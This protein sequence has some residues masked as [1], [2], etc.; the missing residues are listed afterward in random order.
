[1]PDT[2]MKLRNLGFGAK[3][4]ITCLLLTMLGG[5]AAAAVHMHFHHENRDE[6]PGMSFD[7]IKG[8][9]HGV[10]TTAPLISALKRNHP[11]EL[12]LEESEKLL[13]E[14]RTTLMN[15]LNSD[16]ISEDY[17]NLDLG[18]AA[19]AEIIALACSRCH[20]RQAT[21]GP[22]VCPS[23]PLDYWDDVKAIAFSREINPTSIEILT[24]S[25]HTHALTLAL[26]TIGIA[27]LALATSWPRPL[28]GF[29]I[30]LSGTGLLVDVA[31]QW[32]A[33]P[34]EGFVWGILIG[35]AVFGIATGLMILAILLNIWMPRLPTDVDAG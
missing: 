20:S 4:G 10:R 6:Q 28:V 18:D 34:Y 23:I 7:D 3:L 9:Y 21:E 32:L 27:F 17:D 14:D 25:T 5:F 24:A 15:W 13:P 22:D 16:R 11:D 2:S 26:L 29:A 12:E 35:G 1:M 8:A 30:F 31:S 33:R 19:P